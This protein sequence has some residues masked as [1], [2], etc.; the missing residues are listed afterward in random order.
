MVGDGPSFVEA[1]ACGCGAPADQC[2][3]DDELLT[4]HTW[5]AGTFNDEPRESER[6][7]SMLR[8]DISVAEAC[9]YRSSAVRV[10]A[11]KIARAGRRQTTAGKIRAAGLAVVHTPGKRIKNGLHVSIVWPPHDPIHVQQTPWPPDVST[12]FAACFNEERG[13]ERP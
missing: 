13:R 1:N 12:S 4:Q 6:D 3:Q 9:D 7:L 5:H 11:A 8:G 2:I 10:S